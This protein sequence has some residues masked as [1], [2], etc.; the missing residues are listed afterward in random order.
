MKVTNLINLLLV[1]FPIMSYA[2]V[3][4]GTTSPNSA[5]LLDISSTTQGVLLPRMTTAQMNAIPD[6]VKG[7]TIFNSESSSYYFY[8]GGSWEEL[9]G[10]VKRDNYKL[11]KS[12]ADLA[13][14][15]TAGGGTKYLLDEDYTYEINGSIIFD[16]PLDPN[17]AYIEGVDVRGDI[18]V[19]NT[20]GALIRGVGAGS[21]RNLTIA[22]NGYPVFDVNGTGVETLVLNAIAYGGASEVGSI[23]NIGFLYINVGQFLSCSDGL[24]LNTIGTVF[25]VNSFWT[26]SCTGTFLDLSGSF[27]EFQMANGTVSIGASEVGIDVSANPVINESA[28]INATSFEGAGD[29]VVAYTSGTYPGYNFT[30]DW[31]I[32]AGGILNESHELATADF[33]FAGDVTTGFSQ[34]ISNGTATELQGV[35]SGGA[36]ADYDSDLLFRFS[37]AG[38][39]NRLVYDGKISRSFQVNAALSVRVENANNDFYA[40]TIAKNGVPLDRSTTS[41]RIDNATQIQSISINSVVNLANNDYL[42][43]YI[44]RLTGSGDDNVVVFSENVTVK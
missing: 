31:Y 5:S 23:S 2:Q 17:N 27:N 38:G 25:L 32:N 3:G 19:N 22:G 41:V 11:V 7:L 43:V 26:E 24:A 35:I 36:S 6:P 40:F 15:L 18:L 44:K 28:S 8:N 1:L 21:F 14:E 4:I 29:Y 34:T 10:A 9:A 39:G 13:D 33:Y 30:T 20:G 12:I 16:L 42:E 37:V